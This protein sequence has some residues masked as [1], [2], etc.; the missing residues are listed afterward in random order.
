MYRPVSSGSGGPTSTAAG[1][2]ILTLKE[3]S[4]VVAVL[5]VALLIAL[6]RSAHLPNPQPL[7]I[8]AS[9]FSEERA[10]AHLH[11]LLS[12]GPQRTVGSEANEVKAPEMILRE[13]ERIQ[14]QVGPAGV[15]IE[16]DRQYGS[17]SFSLDF[18]EGFTSVYE[19]VQNVLVMLHGT[20]HPPEH[21]V[22]MISAHY[23][24]PV[25]TRG[26][27]DNGANIANLLEILRNLANDP[28]KR[29]CLFMFTG[30][31]ET[32]LQGSHMFSRS[33]HK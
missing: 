27:S 19:N 18:L 21:G 26:A 25:G 2:H 13:V 20:E 5:V 22:L 9:Q 7:S 11:E 1:H 23:D 17:G 4:L 29:S 10:R 15:K 12:L 6:Q 16:T 33:N 31:E 8:P 24:S 30:A 28:P 32:I 3:L 14:K